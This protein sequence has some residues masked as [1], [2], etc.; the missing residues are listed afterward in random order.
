[1]KKPN[2]TN[3]AHWTWNGDS[4]KPTFSPSLVITASAPSEG[5]HEVCHSF[6]RDGV[7][8]FLNDCTHEL[9]GQKIPL[10]DLPE[11]VLKRVESGIP[12]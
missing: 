5:I 10:P 7:W 12:L 8:E 11:W 6:L 2:P 1:V 9:A 3:G 4:D